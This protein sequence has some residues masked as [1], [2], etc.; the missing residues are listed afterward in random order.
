MPGSPPT[1][2]ADAGTSPPPSTRSSSAMPMTAL[3]GGSADPARPTK[4]TLRPAC[5]L[6]AG[7]GRT[8]IASSSM[9]FHSPQ[10]SQRPAH[11]G[12]TAPHDRHTKRDADLANTTP[13]VQGSQ[14]V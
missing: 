5:A 11:F 12:V 9:L 3:G 6:D 2:T 1:S 13:A 8:T 10:V 4:A 7:P 14:S